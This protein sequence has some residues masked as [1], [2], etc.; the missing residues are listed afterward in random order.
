MSAP[1]PS[2]IPEKPRDTHRQPVPPRDSTTVVF[3]DHRFCVG[4]ELEVAVMA[5]PH[6]HSQ[7]EI[8]YILDGDVTYWF[9]G[10]E[11]RLQ[12]GDLALFWG[13]VPHRT[14]ARAPGT[15]FVCLYVP[16]GVFL[17]ARVSDRFRSAVL[18]GSM[19]VGARPLMSD[20]PNFSRWR[21]D[22]LD[23][24]RALNDLARDEILARLRR[25]DHDGWDVRAG[26]TRETAG[27]GRR[28]KAGLDKVQAMALIIAERAPTDL[29]IGEIAEAV[30]L[31]PNYA[32]TLFKKTVG[33][34]LADY[35]TRH[36]LDTA[37]TLLLSSDQ[38]IVNI[39]FASGF[40]SLSRFYEAFGRR[41]GMSPGR[42]RRG[43]VEGP[44]SV[45]GHRGRAI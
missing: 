15:R 24:D 32:M 27:P 41:F 43:Q 38:D 36:R 28:D 11:A 22:L 35:L 16:L 8:N 20:L 18:F 37:Q 17:S 1:V 13:M 5:A 10:H 3:D 40:G 42:Y 23:E 31:H 7:I 33:L 39:A 44:L 2:G 25:F 21:D 4:R 6:R 9:D 34:T 14:I 19:L 30:G 26:R 29:D 12:A 45:P